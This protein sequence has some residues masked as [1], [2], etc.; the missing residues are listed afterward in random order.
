MY[1][2][3]EASRDENQISRRDD[4]DRSVRREGQEVRRRLEHIKELNYY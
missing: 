4:E 1:V 2:R 3:G